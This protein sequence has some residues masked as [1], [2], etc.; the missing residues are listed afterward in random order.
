M[1]TTIYVNDD[2]EFM[3][4]LGIRP[5]LRK[6]WVTIQG[7]H[8]FIS[9]TEMGHIN[10]QLHRGGEESGFSYQ[11][12]TNEYPTTGFMSS[13]YRDR[14]DSVPVSEMTSERLIDYSVKNMDLLQDPNHY[15]GG[16]TQE[17][18]KGEPVCF[19]DISK[20]FTDR[21]TALTS[22]IAHNQ[23]GIFHL[24][25]FETIYTSEIFNPKSPRFNFKIMD[26]FQHGRI[27]YPGP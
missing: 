26:D 8:V 9:D 12:V 25:T 13:E 1:P 24:D 5:P 14:G 10:D 17:Y 16:W 4:M 23:A 3:R 20:R 22:A 7:R 21:Q 27:P 6:G 15:I 19:L 2:A 11:P 18:E